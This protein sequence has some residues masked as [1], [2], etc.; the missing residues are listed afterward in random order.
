MTSTFYQTLVGVG[1]PPSE[2]TTLEGF[3][4]TQAD[5][6]D[7]LESIATWLALKTVPAAAPSGE[8]W[9]SIFTS[10]ETDIK[11]GIDLD[12][13]YSNSLRPYPPDIQL[14]LTK[15]V[16]VRLKAVLDFEQQKSSKKRYKVKDYLTQL[17]NL[18]YTFRLNELDDTIEVNNIPITDG[19]AAEIRG[20]M[21]ESGFPQSNRVED[22]YTAYA[23]KHSYHPIKDYLKSIAWDGKQN[24]QDLSEYFEDEYQ[25]FHVWLRKW[26]I[27]ACAKVFEAEQN[28]ML[29]LDGEQRIGKSEFV[30]WLARPVKD[31][32][33]EGPINPDDK[34]SLVRLAKFWIW[35]VSELGATTRKADYEA[36]K[37]FLTTRK[38]T[39]RK[40]FARFEM[41]KPALTSFVGTINN[42][43][44]I[45][46]DPTGSRRFL[47]SRILSIDWGYSD[48]DPNQIWAEAMAAYLAGEDYSLNLTEYKRS[49]EINEQYDVADPVFDSI[50]KYFEISRDDQSW[51]VATSDIL[52]IIEDPYQGAIR[53]TTRG[54]AMAIASA[55]TKLGLI[56]CKRKNRNGQYVWGYIGIRPT[57]QVQIP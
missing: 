16:S 15:A 30:K 39:V 23:F 47:V 43:S 54:N 42:S 25:M 21:D 18:G 1:I 28:P 24:I 29:V 36:L 14:S 45:F 53:G 10:M 57:T 6:V 2:A 40:A 31:Y 52:K 12:T 50:L 32:F 35:E 9:K 37:A 20:R 8:P 51:W 44:G 11:A 34:D 38:V 17:K 19:I 13:A 3:F 48:L 33:T 55:A 41:N 46:S 5:F 49:I 26:L 56:K 4:P 7:G 22:A 27:G